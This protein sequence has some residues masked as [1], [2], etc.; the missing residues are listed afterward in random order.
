[1]IADVF[2]KDEEETMKKMLEKYFEIEDTIDISINVQKSII[3]QGD[4]RQK[5]LAAATHS[6]IA[7][8]AARQS[9][10]LFSGSCCP[11]SFVLPKR[12][13]SQSDTNL[14]QHNNTGKYER[15]AHGASHSYLIYV[16]KHRELLQDSRCETL[17]N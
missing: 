5:Y 17:H 12:G 3:K 11:L 6:E 16:L 9:H 13:G 1:M 10:V 4:R 15:L 8:E 7:L 2:R 14:F